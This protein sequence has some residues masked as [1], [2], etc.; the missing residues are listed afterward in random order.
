MTSLPVLA[1]LLAMGMPPA[2]SP[3]GLP[4]PIEAVLRDEAQFARFAAPLVAAGD[5]EIARPTADPPRRRMLLA[6][7]VHLALLARDE[8]AARQAAA[9]IRDGQSEVAARA[10]SGLTTDAFFRALDG[11]GVVDR[12]RFHAALRGNLRD[13]PRDEPMRRQLLL[14]R[15]RLAEIDEPA[16]EAEFEALSRM[17]RDR[18]EVSL[19]EA[20]RIVRWRHRRLNLAPLR[21][22]LARALDEALRERAGP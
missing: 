21:A 4:A 17:L 19:A 7:R 16:L 15:E 3:Y 18:R 5:E 13:M 20:D 6:I 14:Q 11:D 9:R 8:P 10:Y 1:L 12:A 22:E 2:D